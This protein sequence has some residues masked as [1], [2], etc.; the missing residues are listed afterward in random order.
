MAV[1]DWCKPF[2]SDSEPEHCS[3]GLA[4]LIEFDEGYNDRAEQVMIDVRYW[5]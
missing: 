2:G 5:H 4:E 1:I 3:N